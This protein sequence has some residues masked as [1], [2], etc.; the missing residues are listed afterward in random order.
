MPRDPFLTVVRE[1]SDDQAFLRYVRGLHERAHGRI[2]VEACPSRSVKTPGKAIALALGKRHGTT[3]DQKGIAVND[4]RN[5]AWVAAEGVTDIFM[6]RAHMAARHVRGFADIALSVGARIHYIVQQDVV[7]RE[8]VELAA[9]YESETLDQ[10]TFRTQWAR[11]SSVPPKRR[12]GPEYPVLPNVGFPCFVDACRRLL[13]PNDCERVLRDHAAGLLYARAELE[14]LVVQPDWRLPTFRRL[15]TGRLLRDLGERAGEAGEVVVKLRAVEQAAFEL[16]WLLRVAPEAVHRFVDRRSLRGPAT[17]DALRIYSATHVP[18]A[19]ALHM[20]TGFDPDSI[21]FLKLSGVHDS[22]DSLGRRW[23]TPDD[24]KPF[25]LAQLLARRLQGAGDQDA[26]FVGKTGRGVGPA[27]IA[28]AL[29]NVTLETGLPLSSYW[30]D[31]H[32]GHELAAG[33]FSMEAL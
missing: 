27:M 29:R 7:P 14:E 28:K 9:E 11:R 19:A 5:A 17:A 15:V 3:G 22:R 30:T 20:A 2:V 16:G 21:R 13:A 8:I 18:A 12:R 23:S 32:G 31:Q 33:A 6:L 25:I 4:I 24:L 10:E 26:L 1:P